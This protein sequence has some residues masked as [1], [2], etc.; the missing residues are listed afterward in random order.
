MGKESKAI[1]FYKIGVAPKVL[2]G[3]LQKDWKI[4]CAIILACAV[5]GVVYSFQIPR[6]YKSSLMII[7]EENGSNMG[8][9]I[10]SLASM[11]GM[12]VS[13]GNNEDAI[14]PEIYPKVVASTEFAM[15]LFNVKVTTGDGK[16]ST[17]YYD[18][19]AHHQKSTPIDL[20]LAR[21]TAKKDKDK[22]K[23][24]S[25]EKNNNIID[26][27]KEQYGVEQAI[28]GNIDCSIDKTT[29][30]ITI[31]TTDQDPYIA[32]AMADT[33]KAHLQRFIVNYRTKKARND[34]AYAEKIL[35]QAK[36]EYDEARLAYAAYSDANQDVVLQ[37]YQSEQTDL[38]NEMQLRFNIY[39][40]SQQ[41]VQLARAKLQEKTP[42][43]SL[44]QA[45]MVA[46]RHSNT[47]KII[48]LIESILVGSMLAILF[49]IIARRKVLFTR[50]EEVVV[51]E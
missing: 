26:L 12:D 20:M 50:K 19:L 31:E 8:A 5:I 3:V 42:V 35:K 44:I 27:T 46:Q 33:V 17:S 23:V 30:I 45:P 36:K 10:S 48:N 22:P 49:E 34:L 47:P 32:A 9:N 51:A 2:I 16:L 43:F 7:P 28:V 25:T 38:E 41:Q 29:K 18:Y 13:L 37:S 6:I 1:K 39:T 14:Y 11:V 24:K 4:V 15:G 21:L 40:Q